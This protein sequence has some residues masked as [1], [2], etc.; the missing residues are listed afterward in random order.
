MS[1]QSL[2]ET[3]KPLD[4]PERTWSTGSFIVRDGN[5]LF[6][7]VQDPEA[8]RIFAVGGRPEPQE[9]LLEALRREGQE[10]ADIELDPIDAPETFFLLDN[11]VSQRVVLP[12]AL[13]PRPA[14]VWKNTF[15]IREHFFDYVCCVWRADFS[16][17]PKPRAEI[18]YLL[19]I[20]GQDAAEDR[21][22]R[23]RSI[24]SSRPDGLPLLPTGSAGH[25]ITWERAR[26]EAPDT[27]VQRTI[28]AARQLLDEYGAA[29]NLRRHS[30]AVMRGAIAAGRR[31]RAEGVQLDL[32]SVAAAALLHDVGR[33]AR[34]ESETGPGEHAEIS[35]RVLRRH[36]WD[37]IIP[38]VQHHMLPA[39]T[40][41]PLGDEPLERLLFYVDKVIR[42]EYL[43]PESR[44][45]GFTERNPD[46]ADEILAVRQRLL[47]LEE[48]LAEQAGL[49]VADLR[50]ICFL[51]ALS[52]EP[53][54]RRDDTATAAHRDTPASRG[55]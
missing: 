9:T 30:E 36:G 26:R 51:G 40:D 2:R 5:Y 54:I 14:L 42:E 37:G 34:A 21:W 28:A 12:E 43:G 1:N 23:A 10:E 3:L 16:G 19:W 15:T 7:A 6:A 18:D 13:T 22:E 38:A 35:A 20:S 48:E 29:G 17:H 32:S 25:L 41:G 39:I 45:A 52:R 50:R 44:F 11:G 33:T 4:A 49:R 31:L 24:G 55:E 46:R 53:D 27:S 47:A 8:V